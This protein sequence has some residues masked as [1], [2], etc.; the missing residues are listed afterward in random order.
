MNTMHTSKARLVAASRV[1]AA[2][3]LLLL[4]SGHAAP[5]LAQG[6]PGTN[7]TVDVRLAAV[8]QNGDTTHVRYVVVNRAQSQESLFTFTVDAPATVLSIIQPG[9]RTE[10]STAAAYRQKSVARWAILGR[11]VVPGDSTP[12]LEFSARGLPTIVSAWYDP[13]TANYVNV[14]N[15]DPLIAN[16]VQTK[17]VGVDP[18]APGTTDSSLIVRLGS[19]RGQACSL[20]WIT[21]GTLCNNLQAKLDQASRDLKRGDSTGATSDLQSFNT[22]LT[23]N[24]GAGTP[25][26]VGDS[27]YWLLKVNADYVIGRL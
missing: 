11:F 23:T 26:T 20:A 6:N 12:M 8:T 21:N 22:L 13:D 1:M 14:P 18:I 7:L 3:V 2:P 5:C 19:L 10:W 16:S 4:L 25:N 9:P 15:V 24:H 27:A 17:T